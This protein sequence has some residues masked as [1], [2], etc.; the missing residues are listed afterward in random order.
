MTF[1]NTSMMVIM[2]MVDW[3]ETCMVQLI[4]ATHISVIR[5]LLLA[6]EIGFI[7]EEGVANLSTLRC[8]IHVAVAV[9]LYP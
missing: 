7:N 6:L 9:I 3:Y 1:G 4:A 2:N 8:D 5:F